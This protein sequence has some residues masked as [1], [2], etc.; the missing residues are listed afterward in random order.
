MLLLLL[1]CQGANGPDGTVRNAQPEPADPDP[2]PVVPTDPPEE[3][4]PTDP[5][6]K[7][8]SMAPRCTS[9]SSR[10][11]RPVRIASAGPTFS[12]AVRA[13]SV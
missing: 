5:P 2:V 11:P 4:D 12:I 9:L 6:M 13:R 7:P 8:K 3:T 1:A 10:R